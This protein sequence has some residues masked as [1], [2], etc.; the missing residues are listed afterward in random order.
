MSIS[1]YENN[2]KYTENRCAG[3]KTYEIYKK[4]KIP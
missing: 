4:V 3:T 2:I 1:V